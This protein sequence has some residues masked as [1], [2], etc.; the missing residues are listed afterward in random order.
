MTRL[1]RPTTFTPRDP[2]YRSRTIEFCNSMPFM[3]HLEFRI[4]DLGPGW[5]DIEVGVRPELTQAHGYVH[6]GVIATLADMS[7]G[8]AGF[9][10]IEPSQTALSAGFSLSLIRPTQGAR[11]IARGNVLK[12]GKSLSYAE[13]H[14]YGFKDG[15]ETL[16]ATAQ[17]TLAI[18]N[19]GRT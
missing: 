13:S 3:R 6:A 14:I 2:N 5:L 9:T 7:A 11:V 1:T 18:L 10:L 19:A 15:L 4:I 17:L 16:S 12:A 8:M